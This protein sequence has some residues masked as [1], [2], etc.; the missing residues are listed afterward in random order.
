MTS[1][2]CDW[3]YWLMP[4]VAVSPSCF[5]HSWV[6]ANRI[7][8]RSGIVTPFPSFRMRPLVERQRNHFRRS[9][10]ATHVHVNT[11]PQLGQ[12]RRHVSH[13]DVVAEREGDVARGH[14]PNRPAVFDDRVAVTGNT[15]IQHFEAHEVS[16]EPP[17]ASLH[18]GVAADEV[19]VEAE[20]PIQ[21]RLEWIRAVVDV[22]AMETHPRF[23][24]QGVSC[25]EAGGPDA[26][27]LTLIEQRPP[28][29]RRVTGAAKQLEA[30]FTRVTRPRN[31][32]GHIRDLALDEGVVLHAA[33]LGCRQSLHQADG[34]WAL[35]ADQR[36]F[37][38]DIENRVA[39]TL[40]ADPVEVGVLIAGVDYQQV[41][42][43]RH[44]VGK[45][46]IDDAS[47]LVAEHGVLNPTGLE[48]R[49]VT[50]DDPLR[51]ALILDAQLAHVREIE[52]P[53][54]FPDRAMFLADTAVLEGHDPAT[55]VGHLGT[56]ADVFLV[57]RCPLGRHDQTLR[58][59]CVA[60]PL[61][62][63]DH[64]GS[65]AAPGRVSCVLRRASRG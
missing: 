53:H 35:H 6:S 29:R 44:R 19:L 33:E 39:P 24:A 56:E 36:P 16:A 62:R 65:R 23:Q 57:K 41:A 9:G 47:G 2:S 28:K 49:E 30:V 13:P 18:D 10:C 40:A 52:Q 42:A 26:I 3:A 64:R 14:G 48:P 8:L 51:E 7:P 32:A 34:S 55:E 43:I 31:Q 37:T 54:S 4:T 46:I 20:C 12:S 1:P 63:Q 27:G 25:P 17:L 60:I 11:G 45:D 21:A 38:P 59:G 61:D 50:R 58:L 15:A 22:V 5:T